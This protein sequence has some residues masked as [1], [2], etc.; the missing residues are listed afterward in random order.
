M[1]DQQE[2]PRIESN[3]PGERAEAP[4]GPSGCTGEPGLREQQ[5]GAE[6]QTIDLVEPSN[7]KK[8]DGHD[9][10][11]VDAIAEDPGKATNLSWGQIAVFKTTGDDLEMGRQKSA[12]KKFVCFS[13]NWTKSLWS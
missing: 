7:S 4:A 13:W 9:G 3:D 11:H 8:P 6:V 12:F 5:G 1:E 10:N 2:R